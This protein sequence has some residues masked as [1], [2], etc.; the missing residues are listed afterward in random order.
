MDPIDALGAAR[1]EFAGKLEAV[2]PQRWEDATPCDGW[3]ASELVQHVIRGNRMAVHLLDG[4]SRA[5]ASQVQGVDLGEAPLQVFDETADDQMRAFLKPGALD[6]VVQHPAMDIPGS[7]L[8]AFRVT[9]F[10]LH[11]WDLARGTG[12]DETLD[13]ELV[14]VVYAAMAPMASGLPETGMFGRGPS[15]TVPDDAPLQVRLLDLSGRRP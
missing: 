15:G 5:E 9:D 10:V 14:A 6:R 2:S 11:A 7:M 12:V 13:P 1:A 4:C 8:L 3:S